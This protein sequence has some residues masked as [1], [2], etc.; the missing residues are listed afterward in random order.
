MK[1]RKIIE[2]VSFDLLKGD[3]DVDIMSIQYDSRKVKEG[4][5]FFAVEGYNVDGH[6]YIQKQLTMV[7]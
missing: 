6:K 3:I 7:Q 4:D 5:V 1:L 2:N